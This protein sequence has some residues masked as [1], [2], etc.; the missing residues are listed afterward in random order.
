MGEQTQL[1]CLV[2]VVGDQP[3]KVVVRRVTIVDSIR[4]VLQS[5]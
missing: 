2:V 4:A 3:L 1:T 5:R